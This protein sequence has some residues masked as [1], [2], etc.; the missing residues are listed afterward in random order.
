MSAS[1][2]F[3]LRTLAVWLLTI[4]TSVEAWTIVGRE[5]QKGSGRRHGDL[6]IQGTLVV[7]AAAKGNGD[8]NG[9]YKFGDLTRSLGRRVTGDKDYKVRLRGS[10][11]PNS[12]K[13]S[14]T[15]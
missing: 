4:A 7:L 8:Q 11:M 14:C 2:V 10:C 3:V 15:L 5:R 9:G 1:V 6:G 12:E 13:S